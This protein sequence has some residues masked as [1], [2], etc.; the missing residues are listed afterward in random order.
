MFQRRRAVLALLGWALCLTGSAAVRLAAQDVPLIPLDQLFDNP[1]ITAAQISPDG[2]TLAYLKPYDGVLNV[3]VRDLS[4]NID[5][6]VTSDTLRPIRQYRWSADGN[7]IIYQQDRGGNENFHLFVV[8]AAA[9]GAPKARDLTPYEGARAEII[10]VPPDVSGE[11]VIALNKRS[12]TA[13]DAYWVNLETGAL[14]PLAENPG[15]LTGYFIDRDRLHQLRVAVGHDSAGATQ[16]FVRATERDPWHPVATYAPDEHVAPIRM[17]PDGRHLY[18]RSDHGKTNLAV[19]VLLDLR[20]GR[21]SL[22]ETDPL[23]QVDLGSSLFSDVTDS[24]LATTYEG[25]TVRLYPKT[26]QLGRDLDRIRRAHGGTPELLSATRDESKWVVDFISPVDPGATYLYDRKNGTTRLLFNPRPWLTANTL[27]AMRPITFT[28]RDGLTVHGYLSVPRGA[29]ARDLPLVVLVHG[30]PWT[31]DHYG[32]YPEVQLLANRGYAVLQ[33]NYRGSTG[34][35]K[36]FVEAAVHQFS[37]A[38][39]SDLLDGIHWAVEQG[40]ADP[41]KVAIY[42]G[43]YGGYASLVGVTFSPGVFAC[44][45]DYV[46]PSSLVT[47]VRS[48]PAYWRP[49]LE[50]SWYRFVGNPDVASDRKDML[51]RSPIMFVDRIRA[52]L[53]VFQGANDPRVSKG[54]SDRIVVALRNRGAKVGYYVA[55][56]EGH[57]FANADNR[58]AL[59]RSIERFFGQCLGGRIQPSVSPFV[60]ARIR[61]LTVRIDTLHAAPAAP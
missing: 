6:R 31:R 15:R 9:P 38:M 17:H 1:E 14:R 5:R 8:A 23:R 20:S 21:D 37:G 11:I 55:A 28:A 51:A 39:Q 22:V 4:A 10:D 36:A 50:G 48:F 45:V 7:W 44:A 18:M 24:L 2:R 32:Y 42:G 61:A 34:Y 60:D 35:G 19:L 52:P 3:F 16:I 29:A 47:L 53:L 33:V 13:F 59:Y 25:D 49:Y 58:L 41:A 54:E 46:G 57:G 27:A 40:I 26:A 43:S 30:G 56:N 12:P